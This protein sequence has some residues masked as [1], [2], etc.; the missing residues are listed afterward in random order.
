MKKIITNSGK[1]ISVRLSSRDHENLSR[2]AEQKGSTIAEVARLRIQQAEKDLELKDLVNSLLKHLTKS[3]F[4]ITSVIAGLDS[5]EKQDALKKAE[6]LL[7]RKI[8]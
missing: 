3:S 5:S 7:G 1:Q 4:I 6:E 8:L 2:E